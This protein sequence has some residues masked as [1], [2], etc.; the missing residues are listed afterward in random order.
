MHFASTQYLISVPFAASLFSGVSAAPP[1]PPP[2]PPPPSGSASPPPPPNGPT[3]PVPSPSPPPPGPSPPG[4]TNSVVNTTTCNGQT[5]IYEELAGF[6]FIP[7]NA[8][9]SHGDTLGGFGSSIAI[10]SASWKRLPNGSYTGTLWA[11]P[12]R[13]WVCSLAEII[14]VCVALSHGLS[15][16]GGIHRLLQ[17]HVK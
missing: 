15:E 13:G 8:R 17:G 6:G 12:D 9:D 5:Y 14:H 16:P 7:S 10:D 4:S 2:P 3:G 1:P 11:L